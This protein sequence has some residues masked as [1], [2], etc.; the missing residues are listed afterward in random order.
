SEGS[1]SRLRTGRDRLAEDGRDVGL[2]LRR[3]VSGEL[4]GLFDGPTTPGLDL[5][6][7]LVIVDLSALYG[8]PA[9]SILMTCALGWL[10]GRLRSA[11]AERTLLVVDEAWAVLGDLGVARW[12]RASWKL[13]RAWGISNIAVLHR[14]SDLGAA[15]A[16]SEHERLGMGLL[17]DSE[18][19]VVFAQPPAE[20]EIAGRVLGLSDAEVDALPRLGRG[21]ALWRVGGRSFLVQHR[22]GASERALVDTDAA[23]APR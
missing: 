6:A 7:P 15:G 10:L 9:L 2:E 13:A 18:T 5:A 21:V 17:A 12:L 8:S 1:A 3:L 20:A 11:G 4:A 14:L 23:M 19:R 22:I 16:G